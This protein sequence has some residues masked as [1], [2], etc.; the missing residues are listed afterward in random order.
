MEIE[1]SGKRQH[2]SLD[3]KTP[4]FRYT[5]QPVTAPPG[6]QTECPSD[7]LNQ[8]LMLGGNVLVDQLQQQ[9]QQNGEITAKLLP[10]QTQLQVTGFFAKF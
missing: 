9:Q 2:N 1:G 8:T 4:H 3:L 5:G 7:Q 6:Q 10:N